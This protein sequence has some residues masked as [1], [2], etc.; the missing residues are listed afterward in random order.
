MREK[1]IGCHIAGVWLGA[2]AFAVDLAVLALNR[3]VL[4]RM[5]AIC[6]EY[7]IV[8]NLLFS[9]DP[10][11]SRS[12]TKSVLFYGKKTVRNYPSPVVLNGEELPCVEKVDHLSNSL[13]QSLTIESDAVRAR[14]I[15]M[16]RVSE[17]RSILFWN[18][19]TKDESN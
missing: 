18:T 5:I 8:H 3:D 7:G 12:K 1:D 11:P 13:H 17:E 10:I 2:C 9:A 6:Q 16:S 15:F 4:Q 19:R 14:T